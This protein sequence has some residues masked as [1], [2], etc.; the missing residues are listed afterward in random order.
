M[1]R[2]LQISLDTLLASTL[3]IIMWLLLGFVINKEISNVFSLTYPLQ[4]F[5]MLFITLF[6]IG[7]NIT[8]K[9]ENNANVIYS[10]MLF[11]SVLVGI[12]TIFLCLNVNSYIKLMS[13]SENI[14]HNF[15]MYSIVLMYYNFILQLLLQ[16]LYYENNNK[17]ANKI[18]LLFNLT[19]FLLIIILSALFKDV[20]AITVTLVIDFLIL[21]ILFINNIKRFTFILKIKEN[22]KYT[23]F[24]LL[25][26]I[27]FLL[28]YGIGFGN[29]FSY[30]DKYL[31]A[32]NFEGL[33]TDAQWDMLASVDTASKIDISENKLDYKKSLKDAYKLLLILIG[34]ILIMN[35]TLY[36]YFKPDV[37]VLLIILL[38]QIIDMLFEPIKAIKLNY[39]QI[40]D[41]SSKH[42]I[43][44]IISRIGRLLCSFIPSAF[45]T[46]IGQMFSMIYLYIYSKIQCKDVKIFNLKH[47]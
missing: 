11:S 33:T 16:K 6:A 36:W 12:I 22:I 8:S 5:Y 44:Y 30:G 23:S 2:L 25:K 40:N 28:I 17:K 27:S 42:N 39:L 41:N 9:K 38:V 14:Y 43:A 29:S 1:K 21:I 15:C 35:I 10:N 3:P 45:C 4:F 37:K 46:Y 13:M 18:S 31:G 26:D 7:P 32:I 19:N 47:Q 34:T 24:S 20:F